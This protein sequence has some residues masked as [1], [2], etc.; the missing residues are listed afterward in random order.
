[1][2]GPLL[3]HHVEKAQAVAVEIGRVPGV[4]HGVGLVGEEPVIDESLVHVGAQSVEALLRV[5]RLHEPGGNG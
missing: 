3:G 4:E 1:M 2:I 5:V